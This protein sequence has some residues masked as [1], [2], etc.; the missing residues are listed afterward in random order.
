MK[1]TR[2]VCGVLALFG[3]GFAAVSTAY[4]GQATQVNISS[5]QVVG[6]STS[7]Y[8][9]IGMNG[10]SGAPSCATFPAIVMY[11]D[12]STNKGRAILSTATAAMLA[13]K[14][15]T[16]IGTGGCTTP[17]GSFPA[18]NINVLMAFQ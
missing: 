4:A 15:V 16:V 13:G 3:L 8:A 10:I 17:S 7:P 11:A 6:S 2:K 5:V 1:T 14:K 12:L 9:A 18:E